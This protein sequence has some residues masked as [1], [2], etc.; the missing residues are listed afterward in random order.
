VAYEARTD[1]VMAAGLIE[2]PDDED[3]EDY[4]GEGADN[5]KASDE[6]SEQSGRDDALLDNPAQPPALVE[7]QAKQVSQALTANERQRLLAQINLELET[8]GG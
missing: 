8:L 2:H 7:P 5:A 6:P 1:G 4:A 3:T